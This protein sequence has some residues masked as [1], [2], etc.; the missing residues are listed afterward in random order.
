ML[1]SKRIHPISLA[2]PWDEGYALDKHVI[3]STYQGEDVF[4]HPQYDTLRTPIGEV[5][6]RFKY[7]NNFNA[8][9]NILELAKP[10]L[11]NWTAVHGID[12]VLPVPPSRKD[13]LYQPVT[14]IARSIAEYLKKPWSDEVLVKTSSQQSKNENTEDKHNIKGT[15]KQL[16]PA[17]RACKILL[18][19]DLFQTGTTLGE[20]C[21]V[22]RE[23]ALI[24]KIYAL[25][26]TKTNKETDLL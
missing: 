21:K 16:R 22:L 2:G 5:L 9:S 11:D 18:V 23:D 1:E 24:E 3:N 8:L 19:D 15:I 12:A 13:R 14:E 4:G 25:A 10:F 6:Y 20:C 17:K 7:R 26:I